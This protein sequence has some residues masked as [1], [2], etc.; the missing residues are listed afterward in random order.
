MTA[1][2][3]LIVPNAASAIGSRCSELEEPPLSFPFIWED[4]PLRVSGTIRRGLTQ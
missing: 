4:C 2:V 3:L 1:F